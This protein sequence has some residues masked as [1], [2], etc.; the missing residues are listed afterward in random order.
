MIT[1]VAQDDTK[2]LVSAQRGDWSVVSRILIAVD[3][4]QTFWFVLL[5]RRMFSTYLLIRWFLYFF[6]TGLS[7][8]ISKSQRSQSCQVDRRDVSLQQR[9]FRDCI[10]KLRD[11]N[12][13]TN[14]IS[15]NYGWSRSSHNRNILTSVPKSSCRRHISLLIN[16]L[17]I[18]Y[19]VIANQIA[20]KQ[21]CC[22]F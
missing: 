10:K 20:V 1:D 11:L 12:S 17:C 15:Y 16:H 9:C 21:R 4:S 19:M 7:V 6:C 22:I 2:N 5:T 3:V 14:Q 13:E 8:L 18:N